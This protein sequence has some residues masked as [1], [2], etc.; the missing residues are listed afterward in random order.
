MVEEFFSHL[1]PAMHGAFEQE[2]IVLFQMDV[3]LQLRPIA[4]SGNN[5]SKH[6]YNNLPWKYEVKVKSQKIIIWE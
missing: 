2:S 6:D 3:M 5:Y 1:L 4:V